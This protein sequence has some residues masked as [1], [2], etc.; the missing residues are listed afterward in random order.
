VLTVNFLVVLVGRTVAL[1]R[2]EKPVAVFDA[3]EIRVV[4]FF[5]PVTRVRYPNKVW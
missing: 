5:A 2:Y 4:V 1:R 3:D